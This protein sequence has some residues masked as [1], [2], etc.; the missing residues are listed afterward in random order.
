MNKVTQWFPIHPIFYCVILASGLDATAVWI[1]WYSSHKNLLESNLHAFH[2][3]DIC[4]GYFGA[5]CSIWELRAEFCLG[6]NFHRLGL[7][8]SLHLYRAGAASFRS[9]CGTQ[10]HQ[11][12]QIY[13]IACINKISIPSSKFVP[14]RFSPLNSTVIASLSTHELCCPHVLPTAI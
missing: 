9:T 7:G 13:S 5:A 14:C 6:Q 8:T 2:S 3:N 11:H 1:G 12:T 4:R 10:G